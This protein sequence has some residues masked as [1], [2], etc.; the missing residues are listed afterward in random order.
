MI[1]EMRGIRELLL[2]EEL[3]LLVLE[4]LVVLLEVWRRT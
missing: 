3:L 2:L 4:L 1:S